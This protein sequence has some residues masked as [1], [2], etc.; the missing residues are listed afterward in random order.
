MQTPLD[1][2]TLDTSDYPELEEVLSRLEPGAKVKLNIEAT[3]DEHVNKTAQFS[4]TDCGVK[5]E[6]PSEPEAP[7]EGEEESPS[8]TVAK[9]Q[10]KE[11]ETEEDKY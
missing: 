1:K 3:L 10:K 11:T 2:V 7:E 8:I 6:T 5:T 9:S 4:I